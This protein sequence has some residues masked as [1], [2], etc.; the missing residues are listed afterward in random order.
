MNCSLS[1]E[2]QELPD[3]IRIIALLSLSEGNPLDKL[4]LK[5]RIDKYCAGRV[6]VEMGDI[7]E[8][9]HEMSVEA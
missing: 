3:I 2:I 8:A 4:F 7:E 6:C 5:R 1:F 9:L